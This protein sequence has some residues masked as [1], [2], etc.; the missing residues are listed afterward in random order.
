MG[1]EQLTPLSPRQFIGAQGP[2]Q[3]LR[4]ILNESC[5]ID[6]GH[7]PISQA[8]FAIHTNRGHL[9]PSPSGD[10]RFHPG[11]FGGEI[12]RVEGA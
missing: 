10:H 7:L 4:V 2:L 8:R 3:S 11:T 9:H 5:L 6:T 1:G 12:G